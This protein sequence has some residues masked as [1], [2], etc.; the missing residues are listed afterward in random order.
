MEKIIVFNVAAE[1][2]GAL[3]ILEQFYHEAM[4]EKEKEWHFILSTPQLESKGNIK[5]HNYPWVKRSWIHRLFFELFVAPRIVKQLNGNEVLSLQNL[6]I[7]FVKV[8]QTVY[9]HQPLPFT[10]KRFGLFEQPRLWV[11]QNILGK[12]IVYSLRKADKVIV[13]THWIKNMFV[14][15][16]RIEQDKIMISP[17]S[18]DIKVGEK[19]ET[20]LAQGK[21]NY[22]YPASHVIYKNHDLL[23]DVAEKLVSNGL[24]EFK[25]LL[26]L[27]GE[28]DAYTQQLKARCEK[29]NLPIHFIGKLTM[30]EVYTQYTQSI[31]LFPSY[32]ETFGLPLLEA[33]LHETP[34]IAADLEYA[35]EV[36]LGYEKVKYV[37]PFSSEEL[38]EVM[39]EEI[40]TLRE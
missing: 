23:V 12:L 17:P 11:Y 5:V 15:S 39:K 30:A 37:N 10:K 25:I 13:Q 21:I 7:P 18:I 31:L 28:E 1:Y 33:S 4:S 22:F 19:F 29:A 24:N 8:K 3:T 16:Y 40:L 32:I 20:A 35:K 38:F 34:I 36:L 2:G 9:F 26:T 14:D 6:V 27:T